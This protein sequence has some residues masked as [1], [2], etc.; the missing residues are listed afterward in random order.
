VGDH[1]YTRNGNG[2]WA[3]STLSSKALASYARELN[4]Y[5]SLAKFDALHGVRRVGARHYRVTGTY[6]QVGSFL[7]WEYGLTASHFK[8]GSIKAFTIDVVLDSGGRTALN[9]LALR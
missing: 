8:G 2:R 9:G 7:A 1:Q 5:V 4:P 6:A 3:I